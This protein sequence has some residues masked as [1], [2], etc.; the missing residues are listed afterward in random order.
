MRLQHGAVIALPHCRELV[1][2]F[3]QAVAERVLKDQRL[4]MKARRRVFLQG[5]MRVGCERRLRDHAPAIT[6]VVRLYPVH[7]PP[8][9][10]PGA[11]MS[12]HIKGDLVY[13]CSRLTPDTLA[14]FFRVFSRVMQL[15]HLETSCFHHLFQQ[16]PRR[17]GSTLR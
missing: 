2:N 3:Y 14:R 13:L 17:F 7:L 5:V 9:A 1:C 16:G 10:A 8:F 6:K 12:L 15:E 11:R 4:Y